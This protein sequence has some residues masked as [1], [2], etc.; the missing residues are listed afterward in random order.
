MSMDVGVRNGSV[1]G[2]SSKYSVLRDWQTVRN[3]KIPTFDMI[4]QFEPK[5]IS[6]FL[7]KRSIG[8]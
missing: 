3:W 6:S 8:K 1:G 4:C 2:R 5:Q 7:S